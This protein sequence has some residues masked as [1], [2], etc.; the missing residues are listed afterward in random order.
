MQ[1]WGRYKSYE[2]IIIAFGYLNEAEAEGMIIQTG[3]KTWKIKDA[4]N[5]IEIMYIFCLIHK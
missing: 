1:L 2:N 4:V 3:G 5:I